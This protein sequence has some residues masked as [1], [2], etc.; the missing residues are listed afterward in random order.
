M[1]A[2]LPKVDGSEAPWFRSMVKG[3][4]RFILGWGGFATV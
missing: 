1:Q 2:F 3:V 4:I